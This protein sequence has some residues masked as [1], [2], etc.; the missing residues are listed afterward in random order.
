MYP[1]LGKAGTEYAR[2][3]RQD[4]KLYGAKPDAGLLFDRTYICPERQLLLLTPSIVLMARGDNF[5]QNP[6]GISSV[7]FYHA[8]II[9]HGKPRP[10]G[11][12]QIFRADIETRR[13]PYEPQRLLQERDILIP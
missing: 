2:S 12:P 5:K 9:I 11:G 1:N 6:A 7:L 13:L 8:S 10:S 3:V 4:K